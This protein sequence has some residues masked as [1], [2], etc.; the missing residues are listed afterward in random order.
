MYTQEQQKHILECRRKFIETGELSPEIRPC[1]RESWKRC[2]QYGN[3]KEY[4]LEMR[5]G[6]ELNQLLEANKRLLDTA[7][8]IMMK[9][10]DMVE[11]TQYAVT[12]HDREGWIIDHLFAGDH[13]IFSIKGFN[14]G[15]RW[16]ED[17]IG[18][19][20]SMMAVIEDREIQLTGHEHYNERLCGLVG[21]AAPIHDGSGAIIGCLNMCGYCSSGTS[22]TLGL[23]QAMALLI[24]N[25]L[26]LDSSRQVLRE[27][28]DMLPDGIIVL[29]NQFR[30][31]QVSFQAAAILK[32][33]QKAVYAVDFC[34]VFGKEDFE[35]RLKRSNASF[36]Y[37]EYELAL[38][39]KTTACNVQVS[40]LMSDGKRTGVLV[41]L[42]ESKEV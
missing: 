36:S 18:T 35:E 42:R 21:T 33:P 8:P 28:F 10:V 40:P 12:L 39:E 16:A 15:V 1:V 13:P 23:I 7:H 30:A 29:D 31:I 32:V 2:A 24:E 5:T 19:C 11:G 27:A 25:R 4:S 14:L 3:Y 22:H 34:R 37:T 38:G 17:T 26:E 20:S 6:S 9:L 41:I